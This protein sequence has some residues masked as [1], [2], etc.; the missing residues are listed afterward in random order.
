MSQKEILRNN[1]I[2][3]LQHIE[4]ENVLKAIN[5]LIEESTRTSAIYNFNE[6]QLEAL[7]ESDNQIE[8]G[9][10][11][12]HNEVISRAKEWVKKR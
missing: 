10:V 11:L 12:N 4:N 1:L 8:K 6:E 9:L 5:T 3:K 2:D 7:K